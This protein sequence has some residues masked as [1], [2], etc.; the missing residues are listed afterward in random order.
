MTLSEKILY[1]HLDDPENQVIKIQSVAIV[2][3]KL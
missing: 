3:K 1:G 2:F